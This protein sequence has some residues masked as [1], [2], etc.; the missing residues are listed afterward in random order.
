MAQLP[1]NFTQ[2]E[3]S[4]HATSNKLI[5]CKTGLNVSGKTRNIA[6]Q[7][8]W[9]Q[10]CKT[11]WKFLLPVLPCFRVLLLDRTTVNHKVTPCSWFATT[12]RGGHVG[13]PFRRIYIKMGFSFQR[14]EMLCPWSPTWR[15]WRH[16]QTSNKT[17]SLSVFR[18][19]KVARK[20][21]SVLFRIAPWD[22]LRTLSLLSL[23]NQ[24]KVAQE[25]GF[26]FVS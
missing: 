14:R 5:C 18:L 12:W 8:V 22:C 26:K 21:G 9:W 20:T 4:I 19:F 7:V 24:Y 23:A 2:S 16:L 15:P 13:V 3:V 1:L 11:C 17:Y 10:C 25:T 6:F